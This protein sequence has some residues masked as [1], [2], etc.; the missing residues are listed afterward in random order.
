MKR[1]SCLW[2]GSIDNKLAKLERTLWLFGIW[3]GCF[4]G[5]SVLGLLI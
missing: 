4:L 5:V 2:E 3:L 1:N